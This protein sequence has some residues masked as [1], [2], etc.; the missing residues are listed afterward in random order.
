MSGNKLLV[1]VILKILNKCTAAKLQ[2]FKIKFAVFNALAHERYETEDIVASL[3][4]V[5]RYWTVRD[6]FNGVEETLANI[7]VK[8]VEVKQDGLLFVMDQK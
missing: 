4:R 5:L 1:Y 3:E 2:S 7:G 6:K 8:R